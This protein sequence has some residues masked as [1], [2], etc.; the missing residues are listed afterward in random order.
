MSAKI[1]VRVGE[2]EVEYEGP[3]AYLD[4]KLMVLIEKL[5]AVS[6][7]IPPI[8][9]RQGKKETSGKEPGTLA[10]FLKKKS[11]TT[12]QVKKF[13]ATAEWLHLKGKTRMTTTDVNKAL[14][15]SSQTRLNNASDCLTKNVSKGFCEKDGKREFSVTDEGRK[16]LG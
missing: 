14:K 16:D 3:E 15:D 6:E 5:K 12:S 11:A 8:E 13:L 2:V 4:S 10:S 7:T 1:R 9:K